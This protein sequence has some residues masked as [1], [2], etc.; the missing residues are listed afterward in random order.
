MG[1]GEVCKAHSGIQEAVNEMKDKIKSLDNRLWGLI[2]AAF[3]QV[4]G[5][6]AILVKG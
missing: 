5:I 4:I 2:V 6:I 3:F 1:E